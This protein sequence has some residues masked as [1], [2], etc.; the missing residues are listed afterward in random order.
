VRD[1]SED[2]PRV[3]ITHIRHASR[4]PITRAEAKNILAGQ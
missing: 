4:K 2:G 3:T 1:E